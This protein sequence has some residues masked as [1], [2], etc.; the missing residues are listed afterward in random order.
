MIFRL[1]GKEISGSSAIEVVRA[2]ERNDGA[3][4]HCGGSIRQYLNWSLNQLGSC[5]PPR[6]LALSDRLDDETLALGYLFL[7]DECGVGEIVGQ[8]TEQ[9]SD[10]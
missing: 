5:V 6:E 10:S 8:L 2:L 7:L 9:R 4:R 1:R 3:Y